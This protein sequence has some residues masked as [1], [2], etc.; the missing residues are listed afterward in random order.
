MKRIFLTALALTAGAG[1]APHL[2]WATPDQPTYKWNGPGCFGFSICSIDP[3]DPDHNFAGPCYFSNNP[4]YV[5]D[6]VTMA[7]FGLCQAA[8][9]AL[10][11]PRSDIAN[12][13][14]LM[15]GWEIKLSVALNE[16]PD[17]MPE[18]GLLPEINADM[19][20]FKADMMIYNASPS[21]QTW[22][23]VVND[24]I[25]MGTDAEVNG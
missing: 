22:K 16:Y 21:A 24:L 8:R 14:N 7:S 3:P 18:I 20:N 4:S 9:N 13:L 2:A 19:G 1:L 12:A 10:I 17:D 6:T 15:I 23:P 5:P 25:N 11:V